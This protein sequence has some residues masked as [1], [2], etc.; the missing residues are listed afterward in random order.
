[1][2]CRKVKKLIIFNISV[3]S[4][5]MLFVACAVSVGAVQNDKA[6]SGTDSIISVSY[7]H[8]TLPTIVPV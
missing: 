1:M 2:I 4:A 6:F 5:I 3:V 8:L 7:T